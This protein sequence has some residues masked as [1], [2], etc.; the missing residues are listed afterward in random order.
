MN[1]VLVYL[2]P[3]VPQTSGLHYDVV[4]RICSAVWSAHTAPVA[5]TQRK[6]D[7]CGEG[8]P[9]S[10]TEKKHDSHVV[11]LTERS[12]SLPVSSPTQSRKKRCRKDKP[13]STEEI[14][15]LIAKNVLSEY[16]AADFPKGTNNNDRPF[17]D[18]TGSHDSPN[19]GRPTKRSR[20]SEEYDDERDVA[21]S[22][23]SLC[24]NNTAGR[25]SSCTSIGSRSNS[26]SGASNIGANSSTSTSSSM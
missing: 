26:G 1:E 9:T 25:G 10:Q 4:R 16:D 21:A 13:P 11:D 17:A 18:L 2:L 15:A 12:P 14:L 7:I 6:P 20:V 23:C 5:P 8:L 19:G 22:L 3:K 24:D